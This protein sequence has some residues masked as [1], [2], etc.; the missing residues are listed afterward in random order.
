MTQ[1]RKSKAGAAPPFSDARVAAVF[2]AFPDDLRARLL[3]LRG[4]ILDTARATPRIG[5]LVETLKW[6]EPAYLPKTPR[7][8]T[9][10]RINALKGSTDRFAVYFH[11]QT[12]LVETFRELYPDV[13][14]FR[15][16]RALVFAARERLPARALRHCIALALTYHL[17]GRAR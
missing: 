4:L 16:N 9:T 2:A 10:V 12:T 15:D 7:V 13:F 5:E 17:D 11:C 14:S 3:E 1:L 6:G 8:G